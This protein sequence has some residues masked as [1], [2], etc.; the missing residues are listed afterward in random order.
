MKSKLKLITKDILILI[1]FWLLGT[2][3]VNLLI[4][5]KDYNLVNLIAYIVCFGFLLFFYR[6]NFKDFLKDFK[7]N[8]KQYL[9]KYIPIGVVGILF[10]NASASIISSFVGGLPTNENAVRNTIVGSN[11][12][13][14][15]LNTGIVVP[16]CEET[17][18]RLNFRN[19]FKNKILFSLFTG[20]LFGGIHLLSAGSLIEL[21]YIIPYGIMGFILS[22]IYYDSNNLINSIIV[23]MI[24]NIGTLILLLVV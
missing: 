6:N 3:V 24:N 11:T 8:Y 18:F 22:Y 20:L 13:I 5:L 23:H 12:I 17:I 7:K 9:I 10:M 19:I 15:F 16:I 2:F 14:V 21:L 4:N 1:G